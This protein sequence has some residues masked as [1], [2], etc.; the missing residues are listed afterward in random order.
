MKALRSLTS[1]RTSKTKRWEVACALARTPRLIPR[2]WKSPA[3]QRRLR[4][5]ADARGGHAAV[6]RWLAE[7]IVPHA[8]IEAAAT[9]A[10]P[11]RV[12]FGREWVP[13]RRGRVVSLLP[14]EDLSVAEALLWFWQ[15]IRAHAEHLIAP[16][17]RRARELASAASEVPEPVRALLRFLALRRLRLTARERELLAYLTKTRNAAAVAARL[18][19]SPGAVR[20][21][22]LRLKQKLRDAL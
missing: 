18:D 15:A 8:I 11:Q 21:A 5:E 19:I 1:A 14:G 10:R 4:E 20:V 9:L 17:D 13:D 7:D 12:R 16:G 3:V 2:R 22:A 6:R